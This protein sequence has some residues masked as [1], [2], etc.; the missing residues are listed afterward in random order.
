MNGDI[1]KGRALR[2]GRE[3]ESNS[4]FVRSRLFAKGG[5]LISV[6]GRVQFALLGARRESRLQLEFDSV[7]SPGCLVRGGGDLEFT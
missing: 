3:L 1:G 2:K 4:G 6:R 5:V 7:R